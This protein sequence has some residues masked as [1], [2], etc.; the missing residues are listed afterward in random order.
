MLFTVIQ[1]LLIATP[2]LYVAFGLL[3]VSRLRVIADPGTP[4]LVVYKSYLIAV[5]IGPAAQIM[6]AG[7]GST[8]TITMVDED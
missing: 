3:M 8:V 7:R 5:F 4:K 1:S 2:I 6:H